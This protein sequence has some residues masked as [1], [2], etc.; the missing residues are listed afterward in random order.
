[1]HKAAG[2]SEVYSRIIDTIPSLG[3]MYAHMSQPGVPCHSFNPTFGAQ[4]NLNFYII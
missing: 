2:C 1:M 4:D 3:H